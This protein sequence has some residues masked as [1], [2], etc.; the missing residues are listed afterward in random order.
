[1]Q[2]AG[3]AAGFS[4]RRAQQWTLRWGCEVRWLQAAATLAHHL[5]PPVPTHQQQQLLPP[6][7]AAHPAPH[8]V[9]RGGLGRSSP[10]QMLLLLL[11]LLQLLRAVARLGWRALATRACL[12]HGQAQLLLLLLSSRDG[13]G[14]GAPGRLQ[15][16]A[17]EGGRA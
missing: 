13:E 16:R 14:R 15:Q 5:P 11:L 4:T 2:G 10:G 1:M 9:G 6:S 3:R 7:A 12:H 8:I 17:W